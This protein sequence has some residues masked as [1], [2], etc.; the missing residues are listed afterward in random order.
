MHA[1]RSWRGCAPWRPPAATASRSWRSAAPPSR[2]SHRPDSGGA[3]ATIPT[4]TDDPGGAAPALSRGRAGQRDGTGA[5]HVLARH[6]RGQRGGAGQAHRTRTTPSQSKVRV[7]LINQGG[8]EQSIEKYKTSSANDRPTLV[9]MPEYTLQLLADSD[10][11]V[12]I[13]SCVNAEDYDLADFLPRATAY[14][15]LRGALQGDA[16]QPVEPRPVLQPG[17]LRA[18]RPRSRRSADQPRG[19]ALGQRARSSRAASS[20]TGSLS[21]TASTAV[22][23]GS[24]SSGWPRPASSTPTTRTA[25]RHRRPTCCSPALRASSC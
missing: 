24:W 1:W 18:G 2:P 9:Q 21:T 17:G 19:A 4:T 7:A 15:T 13:Q 5:D 23:A 11:V 20:S 3:P 12:P 10:T 16:V 6:D 14:Y 8:Y 22:A 25:G